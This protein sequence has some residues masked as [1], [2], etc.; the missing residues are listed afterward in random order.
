MPQVEFLPKSPGES[1]YL[2]V[3][4]QPTLPLVPEEQHLTLAPSKGVGVLVILNDHV[5][6]EGVPDLFT[7]P[8]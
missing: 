4:L 2:V 6:V 5:P 8:Y 3:Y 1:L 7:S